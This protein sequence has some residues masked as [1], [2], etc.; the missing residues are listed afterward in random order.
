VRDVD[1]VHMNGHVP[2]SIRARVSHHNDVLGGGIQ[3]F[4]S[5]GGDLVA[6]SCNCS[7]FQV[8]ETTVFAD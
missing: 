6:Q 2:V 8:D 7:R 1:I 3:Y 5:G 4:R